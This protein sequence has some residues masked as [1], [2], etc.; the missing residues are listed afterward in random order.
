MR[1][2]MMGNPTE[3]ANLLM[4]EADSFGLAG[5]EGTWVL[6]IAQRCRS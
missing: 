6:I 1:E 5:S 2:W 4:E 3:R